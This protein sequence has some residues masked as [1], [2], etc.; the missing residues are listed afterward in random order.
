MTQ[1]DGSQHTP[2]REK[3]KMDGMSPEATTRIT[4]ERRR[5]PGRPAMS[6]EERR[7]DVI[8]VRVNAAERVLLDNQAATAGRDVGTYLR[9]AGLRQR[10]VG[11]V[12]ALNR[13][14]WRELAR[15]IG[16]LNQIAAHLNAGGRFD[17]RSTP[18][19]AEALNDLQEEVRLLRLALGGAV[20]DTEDEGSE[21]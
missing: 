1:P 19:M 15:A 11:V 4:G 8:G 5:R 16:N 12:P 2:Q 13:E 21:A 3:D 18:R 14:A 20:G 17:E 7:E 6:A 9:A 10:V